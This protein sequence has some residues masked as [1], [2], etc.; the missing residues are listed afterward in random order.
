MREFALTCA[1]LIM[2][3]GATEAQTRH[4]PPRAAEQ[5]QAFG[6]VRLIVRVAPAPA[7]P[8]LATPSAAEAATEAVSAGNLL[9]VQS[10]A[11]HLARAVVRDQG[12]T[13]LLNNQNV[14]E[15]HVD[16]ISEQYLQE[17]LPL[18]NAPRVWAQGNNGSAFAVAVL[19]SG[20]DRTHPVLAAKVVH[21]ACFSSS[22][23][24]FGSETLCPNGREEEV[25]AGAAAPC[26]A[27]IRGCDHGTHVAG[28]A[29]SAAGLHN[30]KAIS[31]AAPGA[32]IVAIQVFS[33]F[34]NPSIC[35]SSSPCIR[36]WTSDQILAL[37]HVRMVSAQRPIAAINMS[38]GSGRATTTCDGNPIKTDIDQLRQLGIATIIAAGNDAFS[39]AVGEPACVSS[40][41]SVG[42]S[43]DADQI[44]TTFS[45]RAPFLSVM[46]PGDEIIST[47]PGGYGLKAGTSM[48]T[49]HVAGV[50]ALA[51]TAQPQATVDQILGVLKSTGK[52]IRDPAA[53]ANR[54]QRINA[55]A[56]VA[57]LRG[58][59]P[60]GPVASS[61]PSVPSAAPTT[62]A[63]GNVSGSAERV[64]IP[65][66][67]GTKAGDLLN[68]I[69]PSK[70]ERSGVTI[71]Q[72]PGPTPRFSATAPR[73]II[74]EWREK[75]FPSVPQGL[76]APQ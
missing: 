8:G 54:Y 6:A 64:I 30:N 70:L 46:A 48:A 49:P 36:S 1:A 25:G 59:T 31:G 35:G 44:A 29:A 67:P 38:L 28:I 52:A 53:P 4:P 41:I 20:V 50:W 74:L 22:D 51:R 19:D 66:P 72:L 73:E 14:T 27:Q 37:Q 18:I 33:R 13:E 76:S 63:A 61:V 60:V 58:V 45:N 10:L 57:A 21:E 5:L 24:A 3:Y 11:P 75:G 56:A 65:V 39:D 55:E 34:R 47:V 15:V 40:A 68:V 17:T 42:A 12:L 32:P 9:D 2:T 71:R 62:A 69:E 23:T 26:P 16:T 43:N 7:I